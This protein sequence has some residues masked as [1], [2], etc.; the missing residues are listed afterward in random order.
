MTLEF[1]NTKQPLWKL[2]LA[3]AFVGLAGYGLGNIAAKIA[4]AFG[5]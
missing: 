2:V 5:G 3:T 4:I 1:N